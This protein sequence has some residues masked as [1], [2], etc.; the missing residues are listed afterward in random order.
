MLTDEEPSLLISS[1]QKSNSTSHLG[2]LEC[3]DS[4]VCKQMK[5]YRYCMISC[6][7]QIQHRTWNF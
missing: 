4:R 5:N 7:N 2:L 6:Q 1:C 3:F